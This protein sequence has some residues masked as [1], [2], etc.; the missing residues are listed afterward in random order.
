MA[1]LRMSFRKSHHR[2]SRREDG[3]V[4]VEAV[5]WLPL[6]LVI[7]GFIVDGS[8]I[9]FGQTKMLRVVQ[10][11]NRNMSIGR[12]NDPTSTALCDPTAIA[13]TELYAEAALARIGV[14]ANAT[15]ACANA[16]VVTTSI[17]TN[18]G[19]LELLGTFGFLAGDSMTI[20]VTADHMIETWEG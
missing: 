6:F 1:G 7:F 9:F 17:T 3:L 15:S 8:S 11:A 10:D 13:R 5:L 12:F 16:G 18:V 4:T 19:Q 20:A 14:T 2:F